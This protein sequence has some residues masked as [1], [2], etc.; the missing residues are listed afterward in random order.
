MIKRKYIDR[1]NHVEFNLNKKAQFNLVELIWTKIIFYS[2]GVF[3]VSSKKFTPI[4][5]NDKVT[6]KLIIIA[7]SP[8]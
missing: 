3:L 8:F 5:K 6:F 7:L 4:P 1:V 2:T